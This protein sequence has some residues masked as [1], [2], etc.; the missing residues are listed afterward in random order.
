MRRREIALLLGSAALGW[1]LA[2][3]AQQATPPVIGFLNAQRPTDR[4]FLV[5][6]FRQGLIETGYREGSNLLIEYRW[7]EG[8][9]D[10]LPALA[11][12]LVQQGVAVIMASGGNDAALVAKAATST[13][14]IVFTSGEDP[15]KYGLVSSISRPEG[16]VTGVSWPGTGL[17]GKRLELVHEL[18]PSIQ[19]AALLINP[20]NV[21]ARSQPI[22]AQ[23][24]ARSFGLQVFTMAASDEARIDAA[25]AELEQ[26]RPGALVIGTDPF[27][28]NQARRI[29]AHAARLSLPT[30]YDNRDFVAAGGLVSYG[31]S[32]S[33]AYR[34]AGTYVSRI[35]NGA[36]PGGLPID[37]ASKFELVINLK[38]AA[39]LGI[40]VPR[41]LLAQ[42]E[43]VVD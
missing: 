37:I 31:N 38:T 8:Q 3:S 14:P 16:N 35:L 42:A 18:L 34:R 24:S 20:R 36:K 12:D 41:S 7:A 26:R 28:T 39:S 30:V 29:V 33:D 43:E 17:I 27:F 15:V 13:I 6:A 4:P 9:V 1:P 21:E 2:S 5:D 10:R 40:E 25:F 22:D 19:T 11:A 23:E 32:I